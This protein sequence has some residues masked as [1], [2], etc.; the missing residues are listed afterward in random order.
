MPSSFEGIYERLRGPILSL[1]F[2]MTGDAALA[3]D[4]VQETFLLV[5]RFLPRF[6]GESEL[7]TWIYRI[8]V[9]CALRQREK[10]RRTRSTA[11]LDRSAASCEQRAVESTDPD[12][13]AQAEERH[14]LYAALDRLSDQHRVVLTLISIREIPSKTVAAILD[15]PEGTV[16]SRAHH[17]RRALRKEMEG[18]SDEVT[19]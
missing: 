16:W 2:Q 18:G 13:A 14:R 4:I 15:V 3:E 1:G 11:S 6:R 9:R 7:S 10:D 12:R 19:E 5:H 8:A 17:A